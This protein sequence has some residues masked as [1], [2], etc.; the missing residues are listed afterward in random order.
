MLGLVR[1]ERAA[2]G[3]SVTLPCSV[4]VVG[5]AESH[6]SVEIRAAYKDLQKPRLRGMTT[7]GRGFSLLTVVV[8]SVLRSVLRR[9]N[10]SGNLGCGGGGRDDGRRGGVAVLLDGG[11]APSRQKVRCRSAGAPRP[12]LCLVAF[13]CCRASVST[14]SGCKKHGTPF[15]EAGAR[16]GF[17]WVR[18]G[19]GALG[20][21]DL[22]RFWGTRL[23][24]G[25]R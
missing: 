6:Y 18:V 25:G 3:L 5:H 15:L 24:V 11:F 12:S 8:F 17:F 1:A 21:E 19:E 9:G 23:V 16:V 7:A 2:G 14:D 10:V 20:C 13:G 4:L 22:A